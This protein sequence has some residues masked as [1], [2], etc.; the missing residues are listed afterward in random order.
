MLVVLVQLMELI[1]FLVQ[2]LL[3]V[4][5]NQVVILTPQQEL[6]VVQVEELAV[7]AAVA[8]Q[9]THLLLHLLKE[10]VVEVVVIVFQ[11]LELEVAVEQQLRD[12]VDQIQEEELVEMAEEQELIQH[13]Q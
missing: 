6:Q 3:Q 13:L 2:L 12:Q 9:E 1:Q 11:L 10:T 8:V 7:V 4:E 5:E